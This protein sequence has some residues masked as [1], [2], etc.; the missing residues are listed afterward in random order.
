MPIF[1]D[2]RKKRLNEAFN[3]TLKQEAIENLRLKRGEMNTPPETI[4]Q[5]EAQ[6]EEMPEVFYGGRTEPPSRTEGTLTNLIRKDIFG[7]PWRDQPTTPYELSRMNLKQKAEAGH[8]PSM[9]EYYYSPPSGFGSKFEKKDTEMRKSFMNMLIAEASQRL[10]LEQAK[11]SAEGAERGAAITELGDIEEEKMRGETT[12]EKERMKP[13]EEAYKIGEVKEFTV[14][15]KTIYKRYIGNGQWETVEGLG[16]PRFKEE[17]PEEKETATI[18]D[19]KY[20]AGLFGI[21]E[22][23]AFDLIKETRHKSREQYVAEIYKNS[24]ANFGT[25]QRAKKAAD[26]AGAFY[27][28]LYNT[29][30]LK[31]KHPLEGQPAGMYRVDGVIKKWDGKQEIK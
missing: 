8:L 16:G 25:P 22:K 5:P 4:A 31:Q 14:G 1:D 27:D 26:E 15:N 19:V 30:T 11:I 9:Y 29:E 7:Q 3:E 18:K 13:F 20:A 23:E 2:E 24:I 10:G 12:L 28:S 21:S 17:S 6:P